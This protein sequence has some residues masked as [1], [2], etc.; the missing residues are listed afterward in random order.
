MASS[1]N[2][3]ERARYKSPEYPDIRGHNGALSI[4]L[5]ETQPAKG[6]QS[7]SKQQ[8]A[9][10]TASQASRQAP[11]QVLGAVSAP[12]ITKFCQCIHIGA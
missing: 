10:A 2:S 4:I 7:A 11:Q 6:R 9:A 3:N 12:T 8:T 1:T 5:G